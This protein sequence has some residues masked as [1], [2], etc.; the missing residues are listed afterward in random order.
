MIGIMPNH[1]RVL[2]A[3]P[4]GSWVTALNARFSTSM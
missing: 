1:S 2:T 4:S 3:S